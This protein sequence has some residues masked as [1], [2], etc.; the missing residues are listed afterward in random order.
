MLIAR[1]S[2]PRSKSSSTAAAL[3][4]AA[5]SGLAN[6]RPCIDCRATAAT[7]STAATTMSFQISNL[8]YDV[9][10]KASS[11]PTWRSACTAPLTD[12]RGHGHGSDRGEAFDAP[13]LHLDEAD[14]Q[15]HQATE[16]DGHRRDVQHRGEHSEVVPSAARAV[17]PVCGRRSDG[18]EADDQASAA[19]MSPGSGIES[20]AGSQRQA[21][22]TMRADDPGD[23]D[24][25]VE[26]GPPRR[27]VGDHAER[28]AGGVADLEWQGQQPGNRTRQP[29]PRR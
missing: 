11:E 18:D 16:P 23:T 21:R 19:T 17:T 22:C 29:P 8:P 25:G 3:T 9:P 4:D 5:T 24:R 10:V 2:R 6:N 27:A 1:R 13:A 14:Q 7:A 20:P 28:S 15:H 12:D 26:H